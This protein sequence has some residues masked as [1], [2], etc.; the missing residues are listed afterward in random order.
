MIDERDGAE[1]T[2]AGI[3]PAMNSAIAA[4]VSSARER[5]QLCRVLKEIQQ[6]YLDG[7]ATDDDARRYR[8]ARLAVSFQG[9]PGR[10]PHLPVAV[11][12]ML[13][14]RAALEVE[15]MVGSEVAAG[16]EVAGPA[17]A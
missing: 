2:M 12:L 11:D 13:A 9:S 4:A 10:V 8:I 1:L 17:V 14:A 15:L 7:T 5:W 16:P 6:R 3:D